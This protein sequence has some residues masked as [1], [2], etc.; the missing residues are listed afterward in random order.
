LVQGGHIVA[1][2]NKGTDEVING[3]C[4]CSL[5]HDAYDRGLLAIDDSYVIHKNR[6]M[7]AALQKAGL[8]GGLEGFFVNA[9]VG[10]KI[11]L[12]KNP[13]YAPHSGYLKANLT[14]KG[15][16]NFY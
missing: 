10:Q 12:P 9:R 7:E 11:Y 16:L 1:V 6:K 3:L 14:A 8:G 13:K 4:L 2:S 15:T 5:H